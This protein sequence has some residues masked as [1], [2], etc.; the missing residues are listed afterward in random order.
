MKHTFTQV[1]KDFEPIIDFS[2]IEC[3]NGWMDIIYDTL[4]KIREMNNKNVS[5]TGIGESEGHLEIRYSLTFEDNNIIVDLTQLQ[6]I[7]DDAAS[8]STRTCEYCGK[9][10][11]LRFN[12]WAHVT[13][14]DCEADYFGDYN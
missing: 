6:K 13:C 14:D 11:K 9:P 8:L 2:S 1:L 7:I 4:S 10:G 5:I 3:N 12:S